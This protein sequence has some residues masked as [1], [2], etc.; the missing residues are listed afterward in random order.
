MI[1]PFLQVAKHCRFNGLIWKDF[2]TRANQNLYDKMAT[3]TATALA[4]V[5]STRQAKLNFFTSSEGK[6]PWTVVGLAACKDTYSGVSR[7][8]VPVLWC[9]ADTY[10]GV[11]RPARTRTVVGLAAFKDTYCGGSHGPQ[12]HVLW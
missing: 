3:S 6:H 5:C 8:H 2:S 9:L 10:C 1:S 12:G 11:S 4:H 7:R